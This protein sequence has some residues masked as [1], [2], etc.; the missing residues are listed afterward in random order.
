MFFFFKLLFL[1]FG[2][3]LMKVLDILVDVV[4]FLYVV[5]IFNGFYGMFIFYCFLFNSKIWVVFIFFCE[6]CV[7]YD[8]KVD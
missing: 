5:D 7:V 3:W 6:F 4:S 1:F 2:F 8:R